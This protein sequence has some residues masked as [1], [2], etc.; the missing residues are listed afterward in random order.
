MRLDSARE[1]SLLVRKALL[2][3]GTGVFAAPETDEM[4]TLRPLSSLLLIF[5]IIVLP[6]TLPSAPYLPITSFYPA[7][8]RL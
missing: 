1:P 6:C 8:F 2:A 3:G 5:Y 7:S 4:S